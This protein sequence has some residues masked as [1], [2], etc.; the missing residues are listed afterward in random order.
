MRASLPPSQIVPGHRHYD[1]LSAIRAELISRAGSL[2]AIEREIP[3]LLRET[4]DDVIQTPRTGRR[5]YDELEKTEKTY[6][7]TRVEIMI[8]SFFRLPKGRLDLLIL[9]RDADVKFTIGNNWM[10]PREVLNHP[11]LL[12]AADEE[13][14]RCYFGLFIADDDYLS[15]GSNQD[16]KRTVSAIGFAHIM[17]LLNAH[18]LQPNFWRTIPHASAVEI[19]S[20]ATGNERVMAL[21]REVQNRAIPREVIEATA[22]QKDFMRR[23]RAD[24]GRGTR[25]LLAREGILLLSGKYDSVLINRLHLGEVGPSEFISHSPRND[26]EREIVRAFGITLGELRL[27]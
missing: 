16:K 19:A 23:I 8:R 2:A 18:P 15:L 4:I 3:T 1:Q 9:G 24:G 20:Q 27:L 12:L 11:C 25:D 22:R 6:I 21:F 13:R 7:G 5:S 17:W 10:M 26:R 14:A